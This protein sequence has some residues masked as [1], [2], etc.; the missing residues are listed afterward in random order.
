MDYPAPNWPIGSWSGTRT[1]GKSEA[2]FPISIKVRKTLGGKAVTE[3]M[4]VI[5]GG[6]LYRAFAIT[7][8]EVESQRWIMQYVNDATGK[9]VPMEGAID[10]D[11][12]TWRSIAEKRTR[13]A[14][15]V[16]ERPCPAEWRRTQ[17]ASDDGGATW[18][19]IFTDELLRVEPP[20]S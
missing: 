5:H 3:E 16:Y 9:F 15:L 18:F 19:V 2:R 11:T 17:Y 14:K 20:E 6:G 7:T 13:E 10:G 1:D 4:E 8:F 12:S